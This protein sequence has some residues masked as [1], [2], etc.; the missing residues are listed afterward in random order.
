MS[1]LPGK[2]TAVRLS[3]EKYSDGW[4]E[5]VFPIATISLFRGL[6]SLR[7][8]VVS[9][10]WFQIMLWLG[11][12]SPFIRRQLLGVLP[13]RYVDRWQCG[14]FNDDGIDTWPTISAARGAEIPAVV[15]ELHSL[16]PAVRPWNHPTWLET[17]LNFSKENFPC[18]SLPHQYQLS[19][20]SLEHFFRK[21]ECL[22]KWFITFRN[23]NSWF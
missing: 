8:V 5:D 21:D 18:Q 3:P 23:N 6:V 15:N 2:L 16:R 10:G 22:R 4:L 1:F 20:F 11:L 17:K 13:A 12:F 9:I 7:G 19:C 14:S